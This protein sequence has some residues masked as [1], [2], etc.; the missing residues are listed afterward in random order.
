LSGVMVKAMNYF[1][2]QQEGSAVLT[3]PDGIA[4]FKM[5]AD[6]KVYF[7]AESMGYSKYFTSAFYPTANGVIK[8]D[9]TL[10]KPSAQV[11][12]TLVGVF[13]GE[14][15]VKA[16]ADSSTTV[17][18]GNYTVKLVLQVPKGSF[19]EAGLHLRTGKET[20]GVTNLMEEDGLSIG[21]VASFGRITKGTTYTPPS[22]YANDSKQL[23][24]GNAKW[25]NS[26]WKNPV[27]GTYEVEAEINVSETNPNAPLNLYYRGWA[28]SSSVLRD[29]VMSNPAANELYSTA[30]KRVLLAGAGSLCTGSF[31]KSYT[32][33]AMSGSE[34]G[35]K[36]YVSGQFEAKKEV[37]YLLTADLTNYSGK[38]IPSASL[39]VDGKSITVDAISVN[40]QEKIDK[41]ISL[42]NLG[43]DAPLQVQ[44]LFTPTLSG[45]SAIKLAINSSTKNEMDETITINVKAN[46]KFSLDMIPKVIIPYMVNTL[47]F[48]TKDSNEPIEGVRV[49]I[50]SGKDVLSTVETTGEGLAK[51]ELA[52]P[53]AG[54][55]ITITAQKEGYDKV[56]MVKKIDSAVL[57]ITP[58]EITETIKIGQVT[59]IKQT[60]LMQNNTA[61]NVKVTGV[62]V[63]GEMKSYIDTK[64][65][66]TIAG[67]IIE[68][69]KDRNYDLSIKLL[70]SALRLKAPKDVSGVILINTTID[71]TTQSFINEIPVNVRLSM[72]GYMDNAKCLKV[73]PTIVE[74][75][76]SSGDQTKTVTLTNTCSA[77]DTDIALNNLEAKLSELSKLGAVSISGQGIASSALTDKSVKVADYLERNAEI[78]LSIK[79][80]PSPTVVSGTQEFTLSLVG[81][82]ILEDK[83]EEKAD[84]QIKV[85]VTMNNISK[86]VEIEKPAGG[87]ILDMASWN[88]GYSSLM[89]SN[90]GSQMSAYGQNYGGFSNRT[91]PYGMNGMYLPGMGMGGYGMP[92][93]GAGAGGIGTAPNT[94]YQNNS[95]IVKNNCASDID[96]DLDPDSR[97][98][99]SEEKFT[100]GKDSDTT[101]TVSP[102]YVLGKYNI[103]VNAKA[104]G[105]EET[106]K[107]VGSVSATVRKLGDI[108][109]DCIKTNVKEISLNSFIYQ[110]QKFTVYNYCYDT[111]VQLTRDNKMASIECSAPKPVTGTASPY[112]QT[113]M[114]QAYASS[115][116][117]GG[118]MTSLQQYV[119]PNGCGIQDCSLITGTRVRNRTVSDGT[120][121]SVESVDFE[122]M[123]SAQYLPQRKLFDEQRGT[124]GLFQNLGDIR[125]W[126]TETDARTNVYGNLNISYTNQYGSAECISFPITISDIW[127]IGE[128]IDSAINWGD[129]KAMPK[130][131]QD[132]N[133]LNIQAFWKSK[134]QGSQGEIPDSAYVNDAKTVYMFIAEPPALRI[135]SAPSQVSNVYPQSYYNPAYSSGYYDQTY[136][137]NKQKEEQAKNGATSNAATKNCG[138]MDSI[139][140]VTTITPEQA[141]GASIIVSETGSGSYFKNTRGSNLM[142]QVDRS[143]LPKDSCVLVQI[144][145]TAKVTRAIT[146][147]SQELTWP[148][149]VLITA[150]GVKVTEEEIKTRCKVILLSD[151]QNCLDKVRQ[152][153]SGKYTAETAA[154][155]MKGFGEAVDKFLIANPECG[156]YVTVSKALEQLQKATPAVANACGDNSKPTDYGMDKIKTLKLKS[157]AKDDV[158]DCTKFF[159]NGEMLQAF[160]LN[161]FDEIKTLVKSTPSLVLRDNNL[162]KLYNEA[163]GIKVVDCTNGDINFYKNE[164]KTL[165]KVGNM[166]TIPNP[167]LADDKKKAILGN[168]DATLANMA[169]VISKLDAKEKKSVLVEVDSEATYKTMFE[170][171]NMTLVGDK[172]YLSAAGLEAL[173]NG[174]TA[175]TA[176]TACGVASANC[177]ISYCGKNDVELN[178]KAF[179]WMTNKHARLVKGIYDRADIDATEV[180]MIYKANPALNKIHILALYTSKAELTKVNAD[181]KSALLLTT[182]TDTSRRPA[183]ELFTTGIEAIKNLNLNFAKTTVEVGNYPVEI[184]YNYSNAN[185]TTA[186]VII[187]TKSAIEGA[188]KATENVLLQKGFNVVTVDR[189][190]IMDETLTGALIVPSGNQLLF[191]KRVP[192]KFIAEVYGDETALLYRLVDLFGKSKLM[193][194]YSSA[195]I[196][197]NSDDYAGTNYVMK[198][199]SLRSPQGMKAIFYAPQG[200][201]I[202]FFGGTVGYQIK[203]SFPV[204]II[205]ASAVADSGT[206]KGNGMINTIEINGAKDFAMDTILS[207]ITIGNACILP[208]AINWNETKLL[209]N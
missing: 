86:C 154:K 84:S 50:K 77:E 199:P 78:S 79:F 114:N 176:N 196:K 111:G 21:D 177:T 115:Y 178:N 68:Q 188:P 9:I 168:T 117:L 157:V 55:E 126:A 181:L 185:E 16:S 27:E 171:L 58:P 203:T 161:K 125:Q 184:D 141:G 30:K 20:S 167:P 97:I 106:K 187:G 22:G 96:I 53:G 123:P 13:S 182:I 132:P 15:E 156:R 60:V 105:T 72:P 71:G 175:P 138:L 73:T 124:A 26:V 44:I 88:M 174:A 137:Q 87:L 101:I 47:F 128:S 166:F 59:A 57:T 195:G 103:V 65:D 10:A 35:K 207:Q 204:D 38:A 1:T 56:E 51:Y 36:K 4:E 169:A 43:V 83:S 33:E 76:T 160:L 108:D 18:Q 162:S 85:K 40:G 42:G 80:T 75:I 155:D 164:D 32:I 94:N 200:A 120:T 12:A 99:V 14:S 133:A 93:Y 102:G 152:F 173:I 52:T 193:T 116:P 100:I 129:P 92:N 89:G 66:T 144:P 209:A 6:K 54:D 17:G 104:T 81:K 143:G 147:E 91:S 90:Y 159:C 41:V 29:P 45:T 192:V 2:S 191:Y 180:E 118:S 98:T 172:Y 110:P 134:N 5:R 150:P 95:F 190:N 3:S 37:Q 74:F 63:N 11:L 121:G 198:V 82:N 112:L 49:T 34:A 127:R 163:A 136:F 201:K 28:K 131:C 142:V 31:C 119:Q 70:D 205:S 61:K 165:L 186:K 139:K 64:F 145:I 206:L 39:T 179:E 23:T 62:S 140:V 8:K 148:L 158:V 146:F 67:T 113:G 135:G 48:E 7:I 208:N 183:E 19:S 46:K 153:M 130:E 122:V 194:W 151:E 149:T 25:I 24:Q 107:K 69:G 197:I 109:T 189:D 202:I 170:S